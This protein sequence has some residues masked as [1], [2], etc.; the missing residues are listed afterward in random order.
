MSAGANEARPALEGVRILDFT[1]LLA[2][3]IAPMFLGLLGAEVIKV[4]SR[5][6]LDGLRRPPYAYEDPNSSPVFNSLN[7]NKL[8]VQ[9]NLK[10]PAA[11]E[12]ALRLVSVSDAVVENMRPGVMERLGLG[13]GRLRQANPGIVMVSGSKG[14]QAGP[15][16][17]YP[18]YA[19]VFN[20]LSGLGHLTGYPDAPPSELRDSIDARVGAT[21]AFAVLTGLFHRRRTGEG[22]HID[23]SANEALTMFSGEALMDYAMNGRVQH[24]RGNREPGMAPHGCYRCQGDDAWLTIAVENETEWQALCRAAGR[25]DWASNPRFADQ[26]L[27][28]KNQDALDELVQEWTAKHTPEEAARILQAAGV[29][30][31]PSMSSRDLSQDPHL[32]AR[33]VWQEIEHPVL[34]AQTV[35]G[36]PW[37]LSETPPTIRSAAPVIGQHNHHVLVELLGV[38]PED[39]ARWQETGVIY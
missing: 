19:P 18:G 35:Q 16:S 9:L 39:V 20:S 3:P 38:P 2:G 25:E 27:R 13:Y 24:R 12:L 33:G 4:E 29:A 36:P 28:G 23:L 32:K 22:G 31:A 7:L 5:T 26:L 11:R 8:C 15:E 21:S 37:K 34:G 10:E 30:A 17:A 6:R 1:S 14:G